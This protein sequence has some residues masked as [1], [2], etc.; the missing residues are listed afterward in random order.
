M[1]ARLRDSFL[2]IVS[3]ILG[4]ISAQTAQGQSL[5]QVQRTPEEISDTQIG[6]I[7]TDLKLDETNQKTVYN[8]LLKYN[9]QAFEERQKLTPDADRDLVRARLTEIAAAR[10]KELKAI[11]GNKDYML[12]KKKEAERRKAIMKERQN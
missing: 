10:D 5:Q 4:S 1:R 6:W 8:V 11:L 12:F 2:I 9:K 7:E 3:V